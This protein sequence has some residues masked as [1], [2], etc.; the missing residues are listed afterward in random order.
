MMI[1]WEYILVLP[2][3]TTICERGF[4]KQKYVKN[5]C[6]SRLKLEAFD[7]LMQVSLCDLPMENMDWA[8]IFDTWKTK[9]HRASP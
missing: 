2:A 1:L 3:N 8:R 5:F 7:A 4:S 6:I 9:N